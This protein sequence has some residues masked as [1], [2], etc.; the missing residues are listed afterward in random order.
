MAD[1][2]CDGHVPAGADNAR[3]IAHHRESRRSAAWQVRQNPRSLRQRAVRTRCGDANGRAR[4]CL[5]DL[6]QDEPAAERVHRGA[7][8]GPLEVSGRGV[9]RNPR[10]GRGQLCAVRRQLVEGRGHAAPIPREPDQAALG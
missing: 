5:C 3:I 7:A 4:E 8:R 9:G 2:L 6:G 1:E 10:M